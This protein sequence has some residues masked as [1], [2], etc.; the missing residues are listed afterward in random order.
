MNMTKS[1]KKLKKAAGKEDK[2]TF[3]FIPNCQIITRRRQAAKP[4]FSF[5]GGKYV[6]NNDC[7]NFMWD[8]L[9]LG[10]FH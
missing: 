5:I 10:L 3:N 1:R 7:I 2:K 9:R 6:Q 4:V 8:I